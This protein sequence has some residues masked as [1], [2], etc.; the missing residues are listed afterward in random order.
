M[1][2]YASYID[3]T[4]LAMD[5]TEDQ[6]KKL[7]DEAKQHHFYSVCVNSGYVPFAA[8]QL[9]GS[10]V[11]VCSVVGFPLGAMLTTAKAFETKAA[12]EAGA[13]EIDMV[14]NVG[15][16]KSGQWQQVEQ[17]IQVVFTA[18]GKTPLKV[19]IET[20]LLSKDEIVK[21]CQICKKIGVAFVK[22]S[23]GFSKS[24]AKEEDVKL[25]RETVGAEMGVKAS[26]GIRDQTSAD[27]MIAAGATRLGTS[28]GIAIVN[29]GKAESKDY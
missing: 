21:V 8:K 10:D 12:I 2:N 4:L 25:M 24:G 9:A 23:T 5:A 7:C 1:T 13:Q 11:K 19:I 28:A 14:I 29:N 22:T 6:I 18:A 3:H 20:C 17:D 26:G 15:W 16:L 27:I